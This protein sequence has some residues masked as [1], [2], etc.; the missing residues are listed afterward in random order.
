ML[1][2]ALE[3]NERVLLF[4]ERYNVQ[5]IIPLFDVFV[6][7]S[8]SEGTSMTLLEAMA[9][10]VPVIAS[11]VGGNLNIIQHGVNGFLFDLSRPNSLNQYIQDTLNDKIM[12]SRLGEAGRKMV[13]TSY[14]F[15]RM[16]DNYC[17]IYRELCYKR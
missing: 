15:E 4:G 3:V 7:P 11:N 5:K 12:A 1:I 13:E 9:C 2:H 8:L 17:Q 16:I 14:G 6:L 10:G